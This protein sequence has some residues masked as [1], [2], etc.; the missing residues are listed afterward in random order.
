MLVLIR[1]AGPAVGLALFIP[2]VAIELNAA[3]ITW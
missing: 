1:L 2:A 3:N